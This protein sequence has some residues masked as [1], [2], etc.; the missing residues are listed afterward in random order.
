MIQDEV[1][2]K[3]KIYAVRSCI[4]LEGSHEFDFKLSSKFK[5]GNGPVISCMVQSCAVEGHSIADGLQHMADGRTP[6][7]PVGLCSAL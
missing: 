4:K 5:E 1:L 3:I 6:H 2:K 7:S